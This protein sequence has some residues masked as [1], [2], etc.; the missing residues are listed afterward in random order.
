[1]RK[2]EGKHIIPVPAF[3]IKKEFSGYFLHP[4]RL[5]QKNLDE[6]DDF[7]EDKTIVRPSFSYLG[8]YTISDN[9]I[10]SAVK[11]EALKE[12]CVKKVNSINLRTSSHGVHIDL[13]VTLGYGENIVEISKKV[14]KRIKEG[15]EKNT[16]INVRRVHIYVKALM[17]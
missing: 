7:I 3:E 16:S 12:K 9:V 13:S 17:V 6:A 4:L 5:F 10:I 14:Q 11:H 8:N 15:V 2:N 1:M